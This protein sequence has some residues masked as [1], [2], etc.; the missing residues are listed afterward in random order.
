MRLDDRAARH[1]R[2]RQQRLALGRCATSSSKAAQEAV[3]AANAELESHAAERRRALHEVAER[4]RSASASSASGSSARRPRRSQRI[5]ASFGDVERRQ[6]E[7]LKRVVERTRG[8]LLGGRRPAVRGGGQRGPRGGGAAARARARPGGRSSS[9][10]RREGVLA[11]QLGAGRGRG[12]AA[13][14]AQ[15]LADHL[16]RSSGS[17]TSSSRRSSSGSGRRGRVPGA[18][19]VA[20]RRRRGGAHRA[21]A[22]LQVLQR[23]IDEALATHAGSRLRSTFRR[24]RTATANFRARGFV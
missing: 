9:R 23:R 13:A 21:R 11:E 5:Q 6:V 2:A 24:L 19:A 1:R 8:A 3:E 10:A 15:A 16:G 12:R 17:A 22:R 14:R 4:L 18:G 7:Q 20:R